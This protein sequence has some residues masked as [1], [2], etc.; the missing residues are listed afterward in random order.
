MKIKLPSE[1]TWLQYHSKILLNTLL[2]F[3]FPPHEQSYPGELLQI[4]VNC[5]C[6]MEQTWVAESLSVISL[7]ER[8]SREGTLTQWGI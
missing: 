8:Q 4:Y 6:Y 1:W 2:C 3:Y 5:Y 7:L